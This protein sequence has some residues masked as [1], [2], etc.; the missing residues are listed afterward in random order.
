MYKKKFIFI[1]FICTLMYSF[2][3]FFQTERVDQD[4]SSEEIFNRIFI[5]LYILNRSFFIFPVV[6][7]NVEKIP[8][9]LYMVYDR[10]VLSKEM[11]F[12]CFFKSNTSIDKRN[13]FIPYFKLLQ[14]N[15]I[16]LKLSTKI[17]LYFYNFCYLYFLFNN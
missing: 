12:Y 8:Y 2:F 4:F 3:Y 6:L 7:L 14:K 1:F 11:G 13:V 10:I 16:A 5:L 17:I 9:T 15:I